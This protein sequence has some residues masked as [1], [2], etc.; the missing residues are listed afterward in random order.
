MIAVVTG[1]QGAI[2]SF[3]VER[4]ERDGHVVIGMGRAELHSV[5]SAIE[6]F[7]DEALR[8]DV[9]FHFAADA[10]VRKSFDEPRQCFTNNVD[11][12]LHLLEAI[13]EMRVFPRVV[14]ASTPEVYGH[15]HPMDRGFR[16]DDPLRPANPYAAS[17]A[18]SE[19]LVRAYGA[20]YGIPYVITRAG[21]YVNPR[22][23]DL[24]LSAFARQIVDAERRGGRC[25]LKHGMLDTVRPWCDARDIVEAYVLAAT[26]CAGGE[27]YNIGAPPTAVIR[28]KDVLDQLVE[29]SGVPVDAVLDPSLLRPTDVRYQGIDTARFRQAT[30]WAPSIPLADSLR[31]LLDSFRSMEA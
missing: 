12:T 17:K 31:W 3:M 27:T 16:E 7:A 18:A 20:A 30:G 25:L 2:G 1:Y 29:L 21:S 14:L 15:V 9:V 8:A 11:C 24:A 10:D 22:R 4:L 13:R 6:V 26:R 19:A 28:L 5:V 23:A